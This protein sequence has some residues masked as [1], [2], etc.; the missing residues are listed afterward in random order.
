MPSGPPTS[1][2]P[3]PTPFFPVVSNSFSQRLFYP[4]RTFFSYRKPVGVLVPTRK[5]QLVTSQ[6]F[7]L[8][9]V[10]SASRFYVKM[11]PSTPKCIE[12]NTPFSR[13]PVARIQTCSDPLRAHLFKRALSLPFT[14]QSTSTCLEKLERAPLAPERNPPLNPVPRRPVCSSPSDAFTA[15]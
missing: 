13:H 15:S 5:S 2:T 9:S 12:S 3:P 14:Q 4:T 10:I 11:D 8:Q 6:N 7:K 1:P